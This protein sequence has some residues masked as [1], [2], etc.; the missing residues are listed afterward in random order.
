MNRTSMR[1]ARLYHARSVRV[2]AQAFFAC[3]LT[4]AVSACGSDGRGTQVTQSVDWTQIPADKAPPHASKVGTWRWIASDGQAITFDDAQVKHLRY[5]HPDAGWVY[6]DTY[7]DN[8]GVYCNA[9]WFKADAVPALTKRCEILVLDENP[10]FTV[11]E[12]GTNVDP[13][14]R[15]VAP[16]GTQ[17]HFSSPDARNLRFGSEVHGWVYMTTYSEN[18]DIRCTVPWFGWDPAPGH[19]KHCQILGSTDGVATS[20]L[21][22]VPPTFSPPPVEPSPPREPP[23]VAPPP[24]SSGTVN[25]FVSGHSLTNNPLADY[26]QNIAT[27]MGRRTLWNQQIVLGSPIRIRTRGWQSDDP[28]FRGYQMGHNRS[29]D[30]MDVI[31]ELRSRQSI[32]GEHYNA[33]VLTER[34]D[35]VQSLIWE[36]TVRN[37][38]HFHERL[39][40]GNAQAS[41]YLY[42]SWQDVRDFQY[43]RPWIAYERNASR[44]W[45]CI[46]SRINASLSLEGRGDRVH[47]MPAGAAL[48]ELVSDAV[49]GWVPGLSTG[50]ASTTLRLLFSDDVHLTPLGVYF[51]SLV[52]YASIH[53]TPPTGAWAPPT[54]T[55]EQARS[56]QDHAW[57]SVSRFAAYAP[58]ES[59]ESCGDFMRNQFCAEYD[60]Y[61]GRGQTYAACIS[62]FSS[63]GTDNPFAFNP[64]WDASYWAPAPLR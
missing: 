33:L 53:R 32:Q 43:P 3:A 57:R 12:P 49:D 19:A 61:V 52:T 25:M 55:Q 63:G 23:V 18:V 30:N 6:S 31:G 59:P 20:A 41:T 54:V 15:W 51:M 62:A 47:Y 50:S 39:I 29:G 10:P 48:A 13:Q 56:L 35:L 45:R 7:N 28:W 26:V 58:T 8:Q 16:E 44:A 24:S 64:S 1:G 22:F 9:N 27:S 17:L 2:S 34:H 14:W 36:D 37:A 40:E 21:P 46:A 5:G 42:H 38:R 4:A 60:N 11:L